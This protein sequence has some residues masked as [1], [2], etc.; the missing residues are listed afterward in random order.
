MGNEQRCKYK[1]ETMPSFCFSCQVTVTTGHLIGNMS[2]IAAKYIGTVGDV[3]IN[4]PIA[5]LPYAVAIRKLIKVR[6]IF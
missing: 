6:Y 2:M 1:A 5:V 4:D 3:P